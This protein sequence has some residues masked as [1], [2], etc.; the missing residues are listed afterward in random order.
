MLMIPLESSHSAAC[1]TLPEPTAI[2]QRWE[3]RSD[4]ERSTRSMTN[5]QH[6]AFG[7][8]TSRPVDV[9]DM[10]TSGPRL[11]FAL[12]KALL[13][14]GGGWC[15]RVVVSVNHSL[16]TSLLLGKTPSVELL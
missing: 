4:D 8:K 3:D 5:L 7:V 2:G 14:S 13:E 1:W 12:G 11:T 9:L 15:R 6:G 10:S 16:S